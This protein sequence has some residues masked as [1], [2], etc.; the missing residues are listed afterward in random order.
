MS[1]KQAEKDYSNPLEERF[2]NF[3]N[4]IQDC[5]I[6][7]L[8]GSGLS[9]PFMETLGGIETWL[10]DLDN[11]KDLNEE[12]RQ[13]IKA[14]LYKSYFEV[15]MKGNIDIEKFNCDDEGQRDTIP[16]YSQ[17]QN[18]YS[19]YKDFFKTINQILYERKSNTVNKQVN[20]F[21]TNI[22]I[23]C[24]KVI[25]DLDLHFNDGFNGIF[26]KQF[27]L[28]NFKKSFYQKSLHYDNMAEIPVFNLLKIH[29]S[30]TWKLSGEIIEFAG[31][32]LLKNVISKITS[33]ELLDVLKMSK[34]KEEN[35]DTLTITHI[36]EEVTNNPPTSSIDEF[37]NA[38]EQLQVI[39]PTK[40]KFRDTTFNK[41]YYEMLRLYA[42]ELE[43]ENSVLFIMGFS[44]ADE[45]IRDITF[46]AIKSNPTL[47]V[48]IC[49]YSIGASGIIENLKQDRIDLS[50][51]HNVELLN[52]ID[53]FGLQKVNE[54]L[55]IPLLEN[56][57]LKKTNLKN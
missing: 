11:N 9:V 8:I 16:R 4:I 3:K 21:T 19:A 26:K 40:D 44:M 35:G 50:N 5:N 20:I 42:N 47:K 14:S 18:T 10:T 23:F 57:Q 46:R 13:Y 24:E 25:E 32:D 31:L 39:N 27:H 1:S 33:T 37:I 41:T 7:F 48:F 53:K 36:I 12:L 45:H 55:F 17:L 52:P 34:E 28:S 30:I 54:L 22:D 2:D 49:S 6:S 15:A 51:H 43:K 38:Y 29:G 56:I